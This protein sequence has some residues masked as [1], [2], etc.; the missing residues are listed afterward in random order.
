MRHQDRAKTAPAAEGESDV[1]ARMDD[2]NINPATGLA[3]DY[4]NHFNEAVMLLEMFSSCPDCIDD[5]L[6]WKP[7]SYCQ[8]FGA[9]KFKDR[10]AAIAAYEAADP[11]VR[12]NLD[13][14]AN[15]MN[16]LL[17]GTRAA[18]RLNMP[19]AK[20]RNLA[21]R[22]ARALKPLIAHAG[23]VINGDPDADAVQPDVLQ[24]TID[25]LL[26]R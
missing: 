3:T 19:L 25:A 26:K 12:K 18:M 14:L 15:T 7:M 16:A 1:A 24:A 4:L 8:H 5:F 23:A 22:T 2:T 21:D 17:E 6:A 20:S 10:H 11:E 9:S 13:T